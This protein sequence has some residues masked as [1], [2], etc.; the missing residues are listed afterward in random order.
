MSGISPAVSADA[1]AVTLEAVRAAKACGLTVSLDINHRTKL[2]RYDGNPAEIMRGLID[3]CDVLIAGRE[4][5]QKSIGLQG[6]GDPDSP[7]Y[8]EALTANVMKAFPKVHTVAVTIR[9]TKTAE[10]HDWAACMRTRSSMLYSKK[11]EIRNIVDR[12]GSG[13]AFAAAI[14]YGLCEGLSE[15]DV[16]EFAAAANCMKHSI[17]GDFNLCSVQEVR[18]LM[19]DETAGRVQR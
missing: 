17:E 2:W 19:S 1:A 9:D 14:I 11:Y 15:Q 10:H 8:F 16:L 4:D 6:E 7:A 18:M 12:V 13:D 3:L 5:C